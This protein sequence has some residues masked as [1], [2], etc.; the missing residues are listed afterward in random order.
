[1]KCLYNK[2]QL[3][4]FLSGLMEEKE[5]LILKEHLLECTECREELETLKTVWMLMGEIPV[6][7]PSA[8]MQSGFNAI[9]KNYIKDQKTDK[10][11]WQKLAERFRELWQLQPRLQLAY[12]FLLL[13]VGI[14]GG[15]LLNKSDRDMAATGRQ[16]NLL[17]AQ[18]TEMKQAM[19]VSL[20][21]N[22]S[23]SER[24]RAVSYTDSISKT[25]SKITEALLETLNND[26]NVNVRLVTLDAL[27]KFSHDPMV[28]EGL[29]QSISRQ[30]SPLIQSAIAD[31]MVKL[32][33]KRSV[34]PLRELLDKKDLNETVKIK[35]RESIHQ[36]I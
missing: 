8:S 5:C 36:L 20:L 18:V 23:A 6:T 12:S 19:M 17:S 35:I 21:D 1:M 32:Q 25:N 15:Y 24:M 22:P 11:W 34:K 26:P 16:V 9:L 13:L 2:E 33:E 27:V 14:G 29:I 30:E 4:Y 3:T 10:Q 31:V 7:E 28:R